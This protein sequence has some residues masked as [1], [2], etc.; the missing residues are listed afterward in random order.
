MRRVTILA[1]LVSAT[2]A[3]AQS[4]GKKRRD[5]LES[6]GLELDEP[7]PAEEDA[8]EQTPKGGTDEQKASEQPKT[9][10]PGPTVR[11]PKKRRI[12]FGGPVYGLMVNKCQRCHREKGKAKKSDF[13]VLEDE[14][15]TFDLARRYVVPGDPDK[16]RL[17][18]QAIGKKHKGGKTLKPDTSE[19][20]LLASWIRDGA[21]LG[22][23]SSKSTAAAV[24]TLPPA[25][26]TADAPPAS[27]SKPAT[28]V[29]QASEPTDTPSAPAPLPPSNDPP[30]RESQRVAAPIQIDDAF[31]NQVYP[32]LKASCIDCHE[33]DPGDEGFVVSNNADAT[34]DAVMG[35][36]LPGEPDASVLVANPSGANDHE[37]IWTGGEQDFA[38]VRD[39]IA[40][41]APPAPVVSTSGDAPL[42]AAPGPGSTATGTS[43]PSAP[44]PQKKRPLGDATLTGKY[45]KYGIR[46]PY[47]FRIN[48]RFDLNYERRTFT[49]NP[50]GEGSDATLRSF[51]N[52]LFVTR[53]P[54]TE[55]SP[56]GI[57]IEVTSLQF[58]EAYF[59]K[60]IDDF[61]LLLKMG[62]ILVPFG[63]EPLFHHSYG[64][65]AAFDQRLLPVFW[66]QEGIA[67]NVQYKFGPI[68]VSND[69][70]VVRGYELRDPEARL[71]LT[72][73]FSSRDDVELGYGDRIGASFGPISAWYSIY[74]NALEN[75]RRLVMQAVDAI[76]HRP[77]F[78][79]LEYFSFG[80]GMLRADLSGGGAGVDYYDFGNYWELHAYPIRGLDI[81]Y[82]QGRRTFDNQAD[83]IFDERKQS[84]SDGS[85]HALGATFRFRGL[86]LAVHQFWNL[87]EV[88]E[89]EDDIL[90]F[91]VAYAF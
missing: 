17:Y 24:P 74:Y 69:T 1:V 90:R 12:A 35:Y 39:W 3:Y 46:L 73:G 71:D 76:I 42:A 84:S 34:F 87:E 5:I 41:L 19:A 53:D 64:G 25:P 37:A 61:R 44:A 89:V 63:A 66:A 81:R 18:T 59:L 31:R 6:L 9:G 56:F 50:F 23:A 54:G 10:V 62:R 29:A 86:S 77:T 91:T 79:V 85:T 21:I 67:A 60:E 14:R 65:L 26:A 28:P 22:R 36:V 55:G 49:G 58:W 13:K 47:G 32:V 27:G 82:R 78:P 38:I 40:S 7:P 15:S 88:N 20:K 70:Y 57:S 43:A 80:A 2:V 45:A 11:E 16:S 52:F 83:F 8:P 30:P 51:H 48:G 75:D 68:H 4:E 33:G 72:G